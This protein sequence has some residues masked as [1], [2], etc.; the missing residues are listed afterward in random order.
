MSTP[1]T[2]QQ[3]LNN[4]QNFQHELRKYP[5]NLT[6]GPGFV[7]GRIDNIL[8]RGIAS[9]DSPALRDALQRLLDSPDLNLGNLEPETIAAIDHARATL[10]HT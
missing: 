5:D 7:R 1:Y 3:I 10:D 8:A 9:P 6:G 2:P 4:L